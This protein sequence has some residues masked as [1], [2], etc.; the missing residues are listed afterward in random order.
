LSGGN[1]QKVVLAK[2]LAMDPRVIIFDEP[3]RGVDVAAKAEIHKLIIAAAEGGAAVVLISSELPE[4]LAIADR[5]VVMA[6]RR[7]RGELPR[8]ASEADV[9]MHALAS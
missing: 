4:L 8:E 9:M 1:Q 3:T 6:N 7:V 5:I 2:S